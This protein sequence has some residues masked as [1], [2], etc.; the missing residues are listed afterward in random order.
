MISPPPDSHWLLPSFC[1][2]CL[3]ACS[4]TLRWH[5]E[6][7]YWH[8]VFLWSWPLPGCSSSH[9]WCQHW[10]LSWRKQHRVWSVCSTNKH[11]LQF[12]VMNLHFCRIYT[13]VQFFTGVIMRL[14][15]ILLLR[16]LIWQTVPSPNYESRP[17]LARQG[18]IK[19]LNVTFLKE[20]HIMS[21]QE[22]SL[23]SVSTCSFVVL[24]RSLSFLTVSIINV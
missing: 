2:R 1:S 15:L 21:N 19:M 11:N 17:F 18:P 13:Y 8:I 12:I 6:N 22:N 20:V 9:I 10:C 4:S 7:V 24:I 14:G 23:V 3:A 5:F 16:R